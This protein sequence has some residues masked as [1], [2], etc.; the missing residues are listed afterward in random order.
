MWVFVGVGVSWL[1]VPLVVVIVLWFFLG[2]WLLC[3]PGLS[4]DWWWVGWF[5]VVVVGCHGLGVSL[6][7]FQVSFLVVW[8]GVWLDV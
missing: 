8:V 4:G 6:L 2:F 1:F 7:W 5:F 3:V